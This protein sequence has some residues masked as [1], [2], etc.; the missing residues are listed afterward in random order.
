MSET[1]VVSA[2]TCIPPVL[3]SRNEHGLICSPHIKYQYRPDG[4]IDWRSMIPKEFVV[5][6]K[7]RTE[8]K[9]I[10]LL[11]D[12]ELLILLMGYREL[13][14]IRGY[15]SIRHTIVSP[16]P[17][18]VIA[19]CEI[20]WKENYETEGVMVAS[21]GV[22]DATPFNTTGFGRSFLSPIAE[23]RAF[24]RCVRNFLKI[25][26]A[27]F[28]EI[29]PNTTSQEQVVEQYVKSINPKVLLEEVMDQKGV[30]LDRL[31][32]QMASD[33]DFEGAASITAVKDLPDWKAIE[34]VARIRKIAK[35]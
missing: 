8:E 28:E 35:P 3:F 12:H 1:T 7:Q 5:P 4:R 25:N 2:V 6:N 23:N 29:N 22:G 19:T 17:E 33:N 24:I 11:Q 18:A 34:M 9:D 26:I 10:S 30:T 31:K 13:A 14:E 15:Y 16:T 21:S 32:A 20:Q 27:G